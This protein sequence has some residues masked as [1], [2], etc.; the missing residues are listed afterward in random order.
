MPSARVSSQ[1]EI[2]QTVLSSETPCFFPLCVCVCVF[3][4]GSR[5]TEGTSLTGSQGEK[6]TITCSHSNAYY[7]PKYFCKA[8]CSYKD[9][10]VST[11]D[12][13]TSQK[14]SIRDEGNT[15]Y[16]TISDLTEDDSGTY[17]CG[18]DRMVADTYKQV[19]L[20]V[21]PKVVKSE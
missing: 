13:T 20:Q 10:L 19:V 14:Y 16:V 1:T 15:F 11:V 6:I 18:I 21:L 4:A 12:E 2:F 8:P 9:V 17:W 5:E 3:C 7:N